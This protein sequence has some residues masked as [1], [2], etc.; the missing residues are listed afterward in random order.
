MSKCVRRGPSVPLSKS[1][2]LFAIQRSQE[3]KKKKQKKSLPAQL[4]FFCSHGTFSSFSS[5]SSLF[6]FLFFSHAL[7]CQL[8]NHRLVKR[9][10][11]SSLLGQ[12]GADFGKNSPQLA[13]SSL[14]LLGRRH[15]CIWHNSRWRSRESW[16]RLCSAHHFGLADSGCVQP[17]DSPSP[18]NSAADR[19]YTS[20]LR[21]QSAPLR[22]RR[23]TPL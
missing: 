3:M 18:R 11:E 22:G 10:G 7:T 4:K 16:T 19:R 21:D 9:S 6:F 17:P 13:G 1:L 5:L 20:Q 15:G 12:S 2:D 23:R 8:N 14:L